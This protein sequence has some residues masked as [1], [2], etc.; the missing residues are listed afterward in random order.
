MSHSISFCTTCRGRSAYIKQTL[1]GNI[2]LAKQVLEDF[3]FVLLNYNSPDDLNEWVQQEL[4]A[5][6]D[7]GIV[8]YIKTDEP[9]YFRHAHAKNIAHKHATKDIVVNVDADNCLSLFYLYA[10]GT[11]KE[12]DILSVAY[13]WKYVPSTFGRLA[14]FKSKF[15]EIGGYDESLNKGWGY[16]DD[17]L[18]NRSVAYGLNRRIIASLL[19]GSVIPHTAEER[20][21][22]TQ[23]KTPDHETAKI[24]S[25]TNITEGR[26]IANVGQEWGALSS[27]ETLPPFL[28][29]LP[30]TAEQIYFE[31]DVQGYVILPNVLDAET[32]AI[33]NRRIDT[34]QGT[35]RP[36]KFPY[37]EIDPLFMNFIAHP[38]LM[39]LMR[40]WLGDRFRLDHAYGMQMMRQ[41]EGQERPP[42]IDLH[43]GPFENQGAFQY[44]W[45][46]GHGWS[47]LIACGFALTD[48]NPGDGG[49]MVIPG[50]H[51]QNISITGT[52]ILHEF[53]KARQS[54]SFWVQPPMKAGDVF[55]FTEAMMHGT[56]TWRPTDR[57]RR[58]LYCKYSPGYMCWRRYDEIAKYLPLAQNDVQ[59]DLLRPP[60]VAGYNEDDVA[61]HYNNWK[62]PTRIE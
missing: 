50:S 15:L 17:D 61:M 38:V 20:H 6:I 40:H 22:Y 45:F 35:V 2:A 4:K 3:E 44:H 54:E 62:P 56:S 59:R 14:M 11:L 13:S 47:G 26:L 57:D 36:A 46:N 5:E 8:R 12:N 30:L 48:S 10:L 7:A 31:M 53:M 18:L 1:P 34:H 25:I 33:L 21:L 29:T 9:Q 32:V 43:A 58:V 42:V 28:K 55:I 39:Q 23:D 49:L 60:Y 52:R 37:L 19:I 16:E 41:V 27:A 24:R 51:K